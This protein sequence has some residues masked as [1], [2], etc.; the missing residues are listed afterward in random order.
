VTANGSLIPISD[1]GVVAA[2]G[3]TAGDKREN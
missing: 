2:G 3:R 1:D